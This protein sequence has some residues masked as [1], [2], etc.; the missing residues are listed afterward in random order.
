[1]NIKPVPFQLPPFYFMH[2]CKEIQLDIVLT[3][4]GHNRK[5]LV[6][7]IHNS[8]TRMSGTKIFK[9]K[10]LS[11]TTVSLPLL[12]FIILCGPYLCL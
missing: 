5:K 2:Y 1:M 11:V 4:I 9:S 12:L 3:G 7:L 10:V 6:F 8:L